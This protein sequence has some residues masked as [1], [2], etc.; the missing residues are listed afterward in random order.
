MSTNR[1]IENPILN[2]PFEASERHWKFDREGI[3]PEILIGRR[4][5]ARFVPIARA[6]KTAKQPSLNF[7]DEWTGDR[8]EENK[9]INDVRNEVQRWREQGRQGLSSISMELLAHWTRLDRDR[10]L[11]WCQ[12]EALETA[13]FLTEAAERR[14]CTWIHNKLVEVAGDFNAGLYRLAFKLATGTGKT[15]VMAM[16]IAWQVLNRQHDR[17]RGLFS[18]LFLVVSPGVTI[19]DRLRVLLPADPEN[20][21]H[22]LDLVPPERMN[23]LSASTI[24]ITN[25]HAFLPRELG[26]ASKMTKSILTAGSTQGASAFRETPDQVARR[27]CRPFGNRKQI[28]VLN[29]EA[30]HCYQGKSKATTGDEVT[31]DVEEK[32]KGDDLRKAKQRNEE[33]RVWLTGLQAV[34]NKFGV[35]AVYDLSATPFFLSGSGYG[36]GYLFPWVVSD[37]SLIDAIEAGIVKV[38]RVPVDDNAM[39]REQPMYRELWPHIKD[40][41]PT[42]NVKE[43]DLGAT[44]VLPKALEAALHSL[45]GHYEADFVRWEDDTEAQAHG[46]MPPVFIVVCNNTATSKLVYDYVAGVARMLPDGYAAITHGALN[47]FSNH[48][49]MAGI[50]RP[51]T[52]LVDSEQLERDDA[53][54][55]DVKKLLGPQIEVWKHELKARFPGRDTEGVTDKDLLR[56]VMNTV[57]KKGK[58]GESIRCVVSVSMLT[59]GWDVNTVTH[60][61]GVRAFGTQL[62]C[63]QV[64]GRGLRR[65]TFATEMRTIALPD[66][67][68]VSIECFPPEYADVYG[69]PFQFIQAGGKGKSTDVKVT[70][71][72]AMEDRAHLAIRYPRVAGYQYELPRARLTAKFTEA[73]TF[74]LSTEHVATLTENAPVVGRTVVH[75]LEKLREHRLQEVAFRLAKLVLEKYFRQD[76]TIGAPTKLSD[77]QDVAQRLAA[78]ENVRVPQWD[79]GVQAWRFPEVLGITKDWMA[80]C[81][82]CKDD[83]TFPQLLLLIEY[84]HD[85]ADRINDAIVR[86]VTGNKRLK[87]V[88]R[89][90]DPEGTTVG[91]AFDTRKPVHPTSP[92]RC[93]LNYV[94]CDTKEWE[95]QVAQSLEAMPEVDRYVKNERLGFS[96]PYTIGGRAHQYLPDF[97]VCID[98]GHGEADLLN[99]LVECSGMPK[100]DKPIKV[101]QA[102]AFWCPA[103]TALGS[104]GRW[105]ILEIKD[106][107]NTKGSIRTFL[108][109]RAVLEGRPWVPASGPLV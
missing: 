75:D 6:K 43:V 16:L 83:D 71:V 10:R 91:V 99:L 62:L 2:S 95:Q 28:V 37:F 45:Y 17:T 104:F 4:S 7:N 66:G 68:E 102:H 26:E 77:R 41:L 1:V 53:L 46:R 48:E 72:Q 23:Q 15:A 5:S 14:R 12:I 96:V 8:L 60:V 25:Y 50:G 55:D 61:L 36:E 11:Y 57:G 78:G 35:R 54:S 101:E 39:V 86:G 30:H 38:P 33:A 47:L 74:V 70:R 93:H 79:C 87:A 65:T 3:T 67:S 108:A 32:L 58:L 85:A 21:Y 76:P 13:M 103:V 51:N 22:A 84:A 63:E 80:Q 82:V 109:G 107:W 27:V 90:F 42:K 64:V 89:R 73:S 56:E 105:A 40:D 88:L 19:K 44:A 9:F 69:V 100:A 18:D 34:N 81:V 31:A 59:E 94:P 52:L 49:A 24:V 29:D 97:I 98:D 20:T 92:D 106:P